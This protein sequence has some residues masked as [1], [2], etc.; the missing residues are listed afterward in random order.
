M[1]MLLPVH[2]H[3]R[4]SGRG[5]QEWHCYYYGI[6]HSL[7]LKSYCPWSPSSRRH[8]GAFLDLFA[9][10]SPHSWRDLAEKRALSALTFDLYNSR[11]GVWGPRRLLLGKTPAAEMTPLS[12]DFLFYF[13][14]WKLTDT[15]PRDRCS[16]TRRAQLILPPSLAGSLHLGADLYHRV[17]SVGRVL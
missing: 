8:V 9:S 15:R 7:P 16:R 4:A 3:Q 14:P 12:N 13:I 1:R 17:Q 6:R 10:K 11:F 2:Q 5:T